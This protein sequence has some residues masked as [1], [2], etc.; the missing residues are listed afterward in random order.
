MA[1]RPPL[2]LRRLRA[3][4]RR[5]FPKVRGPRVEGFVD[6]CVAG[7]I[8]GWALDP[9]QPNRRVH[10]IAVQGGE[11][12]AEA[13]ADV[14]RPDLVQDGRGDGR[15]AFRLRLPAALLDGEPRTV[16]VK[17]VAGGSP[18][19]LN[20]GEVS[21]GATPGGH[22]AGGAARP[23]DALGSA[24]T[25][26]EPEPAIIL[27]LWPWD[28]E[29]T[30]PSNA[31]DLRDFG[32]DVVRLG[33]GAVDGAV[34][35]AAHTLVF[36]RQ[37]DRIAPETVGLLRR[38]RPL[39]DVIT[40]NG[41]E[42]ASRRP[43]A[44]AVGVRLGET[45]GGR[46]AIRG[47]VLTLA[48]PPLLQ[49]LAAGD[50][51]AAELCLAAHAQLR[52]VHL[53]ARMTWGALH[54][55]EP[56][57]PEPPGPAPAHISLAV[58]PGWSEAAAASLK[59]LLSHAPAGARLEVLVA[60]EGAD[61]ARAL[62]EGAGLPAGSVAVRTVDAPPEDT[63]GSWLAALAAAA[64]GE[65]AIICQAGVRIGPQPDSLGQIA[66]WAASLGVGAVTAP[67][68]RGGHTLAGLALARA[69][70]GWSVASAFDPALE[71]LSRP[72]LAAPAALLAIGRDRLALLGGVADGRLP[73]GGADL[74]LG[75]R[76]RRLGL[77]SVL[78]GGLS[79]EADALA[80][81]AGELSGAA[82]AAFD[83]A[84]LVAAASAYPPP[85]SQ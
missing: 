51:R 22:P 60:A 85:L 44:R 31:T 32:G 36:A 34:L 61:A 71:G 55:G 80:A 28:G 16:E 62:A 73:A 77:A 14:W 79:A 29:A 40:W 48:G 59:A 15:H 19:A 65:V 11:V 20:R 5:V 82:L 81:P 43:E 72:V 74:D 21:I 66:A 27:A 46:F 69:D 83:P 64:S 35:A 17:A 53:P 76:L 25:P 12:V 7:E 26:A 39:A 3:L 30:I 8:R 67:I 78:L 49:A 63:P 24:A 42:L 1:D 75:L 41:L 38:S 50:A 13:L 6:G 33:A 2:L 10:V 54:M 9:D 52:W 84:E 37:G 56:P 23:R 68:R 4:W 47:H 58:W 18:A 70:D 45:L 57:A